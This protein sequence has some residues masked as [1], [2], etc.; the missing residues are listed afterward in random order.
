L[1]WEDLLI[2]FWASFPIK[3]MKLLFLATTH[4]GWSKLL[5]EGVVMHFPCDNLRILVFSMPSSYDLKDDLGS[6]L[7]VVST[8]AAS[9]F[10][11]RKIQDFD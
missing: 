6:W 5:H 4:K 1:D 2:A 11:T 10:G 7:H 9:H 3:A 8:N